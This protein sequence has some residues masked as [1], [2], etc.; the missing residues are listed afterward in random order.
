M[1]EDAAKMPTAARRVP[2]AACLAACL[3]AAL[4]A[5]ATA[6]KSSAD[7]TPPPLNGMIY[8]YDNLPVSGAVV[9]AEGEDLAASDVNGRFSLPAFPFGKYRF[10]A[11]RSGYEPS[12]LEADY[13]D[14]TQVLYFKMHSAEQLLARAERALDARDWQAAESF[15][16]RAS[17]VKPGD[18]AVL[19]L[20]AVLDYRRGR[21]V[22]AL[23]KLESVLA[24]DPR[25]PFVYLFMADLH[26]YGLADKAKALAA[27]DA[28]LDLR[29]DREAE[30]RRR[31]LASELGAAAEEPAASAP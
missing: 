7:P 29:Y 12:E 13:A 8:D 23:A 4:S 21:C 5:C 19:Y 22:D 16:A 31:S 14:A 24:A 27:L 3:A 28:F 11:S 25:D 2:A 9:S 1:N 20:A 17:A 6:G 15:I 26:Q 30:E 10:T 18:P